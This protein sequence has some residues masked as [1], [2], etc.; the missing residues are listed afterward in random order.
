MHLLT[1]EKQ[2]IS[3]HFSAA[4]WHSQPA[5]RTNEKY[6]PSKEEL[7]NE[8]LTSLLRLNTSGFKGF[9]LRES[10]S[11]QLRDREPEYCYMILGAVQ[12]TFIT[13]FTSLAY[14][15]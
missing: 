5:E 3:D 7:I 9:G 1:G 10:F 2:L 13:L 6:L 4:L 15:V 12:Q 11:S 14:I 8:L